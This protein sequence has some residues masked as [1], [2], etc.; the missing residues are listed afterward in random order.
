MKTRSN[1][2]ISYSKYFFY[3]IISIPILIFAAIIFYTLAPKFS[4][5]SQNVNPAKSSLIQ[6]LDAMPSVSVAPITQQQKDVIF[7]KKLDPEQAKVNQSG[8]VYQSARKQIDSSQIKP[9]TDEE[10]QAIL[11]KK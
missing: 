3:A 4:R 7:N 8:E 10:V 2:S 11:N 6:G 5:L 1:R 9:L